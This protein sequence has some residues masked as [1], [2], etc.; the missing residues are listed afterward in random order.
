MIRI[1][2]I[3]AVVLATTT[4]D[5]ALPPF[6]QR[7]AEIRA[8]LDS[9]AVADALMPHGPIDSIERVE[10]DHYR[11]KA[12]PCVLDV[13]IVDDPSAE[14]SNMPGPRRFKVELGALACN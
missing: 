1:V 13:L 2:A 5:A 12:G 11:V 6:W 8:I 10:T 9:D 7:T 3:L 4:A 14:G